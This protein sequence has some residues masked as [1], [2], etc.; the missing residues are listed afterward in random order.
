MPQPFLSTHASPQALGR[1]PLFAAALVGAALVFGGAGGGFA[2]AAIG[3][4]FSGACFAAGAALARRRS[5]SDAAA[6]IASLLESLTRS[7]VSTPVPT[8]LNPADFA[9]AAKA[10]DAVRE[11]LGAVRRADSHAQVVRQAAEARQLNDEANLAQFRA[12]LGAALG[13]VANN[14]EQMSLA[15]DQL[16]LIATLS[17]SRAK[18]VSNSTLESQASTGNVVLASKALAHNFKEI[19]G[20]VVST[21]AAV[22]EAKGTTTLTT[23]SIDGLAIKANEI[24]EIVGLIQAVAAQTNLLALN[25]TIEAARAGEAGR[26]FGVVAQE[27]K[28]LAGQTARATE[29]IGEHVAA[30]QRSVSEAVEAIAA[31]SV[32]MHQADGLTESIAASI[33]AQTNVTND[34]LA[35]VAKAA[36]GAGLTVSAMQG[37]NG[38][39]SETG[40]AAEQ[41][42][43]TAIDAA[44]HSKALREIVDGYLLSVSAA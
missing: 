39:V 18:D 25:A 8:I 28:S 42:R 16:S 41:V 40:D 21:R 11:A 9:R 36:Q 33:K 24:G 12:K 19:E 30:I 17:A 34:I 43:R 35:G 31:I 1:A 2:W 32:S 29:R 10:L 14:S 4:V 3:A 38:V 7:E 20:R 6:E 44:T 13:Q 27:V 26:G 15:A 22:I 5:A 37:L 23:Q